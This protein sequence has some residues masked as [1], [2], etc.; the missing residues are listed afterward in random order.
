MSYI[1]ENRPGFPRAFVRVTDETER[2]AY[3]RERAWR[4]NSLANERATD[5]AQE[6]AARRLSEYDE[7]ND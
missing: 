2:E 4:R 3:E 1:T 6:D 7:R 5:L